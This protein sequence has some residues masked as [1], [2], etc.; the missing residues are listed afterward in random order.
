[1]NHELKN[2]STTH[3]FIMEIPNRR[4]RQQ[5]AINHSSDIDFKDVIKIYKKCTPEKYSFL[6]KDTTLASDNQLKQ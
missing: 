6:V 5:I 1:M 4:G 2:L 3:Y